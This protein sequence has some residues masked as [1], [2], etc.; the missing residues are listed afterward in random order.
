VLSFGFV[1]IHPISSKQAQAK[2]SKES[3]SKTSPAKSDST[4][5]TPI[6]SDVQAVSP[7]APLSTVPIAAQT[8]NQQ[9]KPNQKAK[10][11]LLW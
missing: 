6:N 1:L 10:K 2:V 11:A 3:G 4:Q 5:Q 8:H 7:A 9:P